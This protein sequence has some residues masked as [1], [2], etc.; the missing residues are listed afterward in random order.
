MGV[1]MTRK[2]GFRTALDVLRRPAVN[3]DGALA[4]AFTAV[5]A[6]RTDVDPGRCASDIHHDRP[7]T[8][9]GTFRVNPFQAGPTDK[10]GVGYCAQ[11][12]HTLHLVGWFQPDEGQQ[13]PGEE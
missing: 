3:P 11:C 2:T 8:V 1:T 10:T 12:A 7:A 9:W 4:A 6:G 13:V 5:P